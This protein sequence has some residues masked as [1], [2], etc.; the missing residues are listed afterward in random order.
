M[1]RAAEGKDHPKR[2]KIKTAAH[3]IF[4][5]LHRV[6]ASAKVGVVLYPQYLKLKG[7]N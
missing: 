1:C 2:K 7:C 4:E 6:E 5:L 3:A